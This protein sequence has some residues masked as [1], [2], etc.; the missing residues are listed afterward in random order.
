MKIAQEVRA[1][2]VIMIGTN[3][4]GHSAEQVAGGIKAIVDELK[5]QKPGIKI[6]LLGVFPRGGGGDAER[7]LEQITDSIKPIN[8]ELKK[9]TPDLQRLNAL[10]KA[11]EQKKGAIP[12]AKL[13][14]KIADI[15]AIIAKLDDG[16]NVRYL[17]INHVFLGQDGKIPFSIM[18]DQL[19]PNAA[20][21]QLWADAMQ[22]LLS[23]MMK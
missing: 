15:N 17:D 14:K 19:H 9:D 7:S 21:Y 10:V 13:N 8:E 5:K 4:G 20:G 6:L 1:G 12:A 3:N 11:L 22:P 2:N 18:P 23:E 16:K